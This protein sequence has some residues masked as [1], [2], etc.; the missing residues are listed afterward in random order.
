MGRTPTYYLPRSQECPPTPL[1][2][3]RAQECQETKGAQ[4]CRS[5]K[6]TQECSQKVAQECTSKIEEDTDLGN[7]DGDNDNPPP[8]LS[9][10]ANEDDSDDEDDE[11]DEDVDDSKDIESHHD[12]TPDEKVYHPDSMTP[13]VQRTH[14]L[15]PRKPRDYSHMFSHAN[16]MH[17]AMTQYSLRK[18]LNKF[19][20]V[21][22]EAVSK[23]LKQLHMRDTLSPQNSEEMSDEQKRGALE[24]LMFLKEKR[25]VSVK[26][27]ACADGMKQR[28]TDVPGDST[29]PT[30]ALESVLITAT[31]DAFE[32]RGVAI[33][34]VPGVF[35]SADMDEE[36]IMTIRGRL[37]ELMVKA[38]PNIYRKNITI[39]ANNRPLLYWK[40]QKALYGCIISTLL[41]Y[42]KLVGDL[43]LQGFELNPHVP[44]VANKMINGNQFTLTWHVDDTK[45]SHDDHKEVTRVIDWLKGIYGDNMHVWRGLVHDYLGM[46]LDYSTKGEVKVTMVDYLKGVQG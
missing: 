20:K 14:G 26:G 27:R 23:K 21:G 3:L 25:D 4:E 2:P 32:G 40:L 38:D 12:E 6:G 16:V 36:V 31:I 24:S 18:G 8:L 30:V 1:I 39:D 37:A 42:Q 15:R 44:C 13:S 34:D 35:L 7:S 33:V 46:T 10:T 5:L 45:M 28:D 17:H 43:K 29:S 9:R 22:E 19:Q 41:F 11:D